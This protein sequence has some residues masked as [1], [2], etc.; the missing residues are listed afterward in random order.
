VRDQIHALA[1]LLLLSSHKT[2]SGFLGKERSHVMINIGSVEGVEQQLFCFEPEI[3]A[4]TNSCTNK[5][6]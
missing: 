2:P 6:G 3:N 5:A 4:Q 1:A